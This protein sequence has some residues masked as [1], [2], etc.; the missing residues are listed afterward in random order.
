MKQFGGIIY[1]PEKDWREYYSY[2][3]SELGIFDKQVIFRLVTD[4]A[5]NPEMCYCSVIGEPLEDEKDNFK[6]LKQINYD[7]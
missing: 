4:V 6:W 1:I 5:N 2:L 7:R 3:C